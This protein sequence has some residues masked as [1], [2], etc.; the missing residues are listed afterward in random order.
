MRK[1]TQ[2]GAIQSALEGTVSIEERQPWNV[3]L[4]KGAGFGEDKGAGIVNHYEVECGLVG[5]FCN[6][7]EGNEQ[8]IEDR[9]EGL[10]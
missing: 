6:G 10:C 7:L 5:S 8:T 9:A 2:E 3:I 1:F 4:E